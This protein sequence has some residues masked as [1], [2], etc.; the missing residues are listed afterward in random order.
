M[1]IINSILGK[2]HIKKMIAESLNTEIW[3]AEEEPYAELSEKEL[4]LI[5]KG[6]PN[7]ATNSI[8]RK[9][10]SIDAPIQE[11][12]DSINGVLEK[13]H[14]KNKVVVYRGQ[15]SIE[16]ETRLASEKG[17]P[18]NMLYYD[19]YVSCSLVKGYHFNSRRYKFIIT[20]DEGTSYLYKGISPEGHLK[21]IVFPI[22]SIF[23]IEKEYEIGD[24]TYI[25]GHLKR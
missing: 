11:I 14:L 1:D 18:S 16:Y 21:E 19:A 12:I 10:H 24:D 23:V 22:G 13:K 7:T 25:E 9:H 6:E 3:E 17:L 5:R 8:I 4:E 20:A 2:H 15:E